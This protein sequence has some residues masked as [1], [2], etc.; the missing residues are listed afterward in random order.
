MQFEIVVMADKVSKEARSKIMSTIRGRNTKPELFVRSKLFR[1]GFRFRLHH[2]GL[3]GNPDIV[4]TQFRTIVFVHGCFWH[5]HD[6]KKGREIPNTRTKF[7]RAKLEG[8]AARDQVNQRALTMEGWKVFLIWTCRIESDTE[9]VLIY[10]R[11]L[12]NSKLTKTGS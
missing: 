1:E 10:L 8:N 11:K 4:L 12:R 9:Q 3:V 5:R 2:H 6:C 7:W